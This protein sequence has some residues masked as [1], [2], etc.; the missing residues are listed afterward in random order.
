MLIYAGSRQRGLSLS[1]LIATIAIFGFL[2]LVAARALPAWTEFMAIK[3]ITSEL[4][5][6]TASSSSEIRKQFNQKKSADYVE[7]VRGED[8]TI[9]KNGDGWDITFSYEKRIPLAG[10]ASLVFDFS[11]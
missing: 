4:S 6:S 3:R 10:N 1:G 7:S 5:T 11:N 8:L 9:E 2:A